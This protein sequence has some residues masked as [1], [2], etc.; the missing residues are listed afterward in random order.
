MFE[1]LLKKKIKMT[2]VLTK[3]GMMVRK[4]SF[5]L[6]KVAVD[7]IGYIECEGL[8]I[9]HDDIFMWLVI[10]TRDGKVVNVTSADLH[11]I[12]IEHPSGKIR[13]TPCHRTYQWI[14]KE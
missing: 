7:R 1:D 2:H 8:E 14:K 13:F 3:N 11:I 9:E 5:D 10:Q 6:S 12:C 4:A